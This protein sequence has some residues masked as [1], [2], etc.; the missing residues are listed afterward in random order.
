[1]NNT[2]IFISLILLTSSINTTL[3]AKLKGKIFTPKDCLPRV[4]ETYVAS[5]APSQSLK[6]DDSMLE[7]CPDLHESCCLK[8]N[9]NDLHSLVL[10]GIK[11]LRSFEHEYNYVMQT[12]NKASDLTVEK[13]IKDFAQKI[14]GV[15]DIVDDEEEDPKV[16]KLRESINYI[17][18]NESLISEDLKSAIE[19][20]I[21]VNSRFGCAICNRENLFSFKNMKTKSPSLI[22]DMAQCKNIFS[23]KRAMSIFLLDH[24]TTYLYETIVAMAFVENGSSPSDTFLT[25][26]EISNLPSLIEK[27]K[28]DSN[29]ITNLECQSLCLG[30]KFFNENPFYNI[31]KQ[32]TAG[33]IM[34]DHYFKGLQK[35]SKVELNQEYENL[36]KKIVKR[37]FVMPHL[38][39]TFLIENFPKQFSWNSGWNI[40]SFEMNFNTEVKHVENKNLEDFILKAP[41]TEQELFQVTSSSVN[42][43]QDDES[44]SSKIINYFVSFLLLFMLSN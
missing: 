43:V 33:N 3:T 19:M 17:K 4:I 6:S 14:N 37:F 1:M 10:D 13:F 36:E 9:L 23:D 34:I 16:T 15:M 41:R 32:I 29:F 20:V 28:D 18:K 31:Q 38:P 2:I 5:K 39:V 25:K 27:C 11:S 8:N 42:F 12:I 30:M 21:S 22:L 24:H 26:D 40:M 7:L 35:K 44:E